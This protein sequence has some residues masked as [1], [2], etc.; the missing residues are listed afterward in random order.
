MRGLQDGFPQLRST[1]R[2]LYVFTAHLSVYNPVIH[3]DRPFQRP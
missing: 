1:I 2:K 3:I